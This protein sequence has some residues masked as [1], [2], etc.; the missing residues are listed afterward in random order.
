MRIT[1]I[2]RQPRKRRYEVRV[3]F[4]LVLPLSPEVLA[5]ACLQ[6]GQEVTTGQLKTLEEA[7]A[8]HTAMASALR[9]LSFRQRSEKEMR[10]DLKRRRIPQ[11]ILDET[12]ERLRTLRLL[13]DA[14]F[15][16][17]YVDSRART[18]PRGRR[19]IRAEL[20]SRGLTRAE[21]EEPLAAFDEQDAAY[22]AAARRARSLDKLAYPD[23]QRRL[24]DHLLRRG[25]GYETARETVKR[26]WQEVRGDAPA[27]VID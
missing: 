4:A 18:S 21:A 11:D 12:V 17:S 6:T 27:E 22:R 2:E 7:E 20:L 26:V 9:L 25:F 15:A 14:E 16:R 19:L 10:D 3:D 5:Q 1:S 8:R 23:F 24:G 13:D